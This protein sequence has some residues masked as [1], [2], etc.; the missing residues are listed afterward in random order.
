MIKYLECPDLHYHPG[1]LTDIGARIAEAAR[2]NEVDFIALPGDLYDAPIMATDKGGINELRKIVREWLSVCPVIAIE[3]T[4]SHDGP[5]CYGPLEDMG[6][7]LLKPGTVYGLTEFGIIQLIND[8][9]PRPSAI[10]F[11]IPELNKKQIQAQ[12][13]LPAEQANAEAVNLFTRYVAEFIAPMR[14]KYA[15]LPAIALLHGV[16]SDARKENTTDV[17]IKASDIVIHTEDLRPANI[18]R[19]SLGHIHK[20][21][22]SSEIC[23]GY[24]GSWGKDW[25]EL[26]FKPGMNMVMIDGAVTLSRIHYGTPE[27]RKIIHPLSQY[28]PEIAYLFETDDPDAAAPTGHP[29]SELRY[30]PKPKETRR[31]TKEQADLAKTLQELFKLFDPAAPETAIKKLDEIIEKVKQRSVN[32]ID[33]QLQY[34]K[35]DGCIF[36]KGKSVEFDL[37]TIDGVTELHGEGNGV[38]K[39]GLLAFCS[40][41]PVVIGKDTDSGRASAIKD[42]FEAPDSMVIKKL[43]VNGVQH[44][45]IITIKGAH[46]QTPKVECCLTIDGR[47]QLDKGT[48][49]EMMET[50]EKLY[51][52]YLDY[53]LTTFYVQPLQGT[54]GSSLMSA[55]LIDIRNLVQSIAGIDRE[56]EKEYALLKVKTLTKESDDLTNWLKGAEEFKADISALA[57][58]LTEHEIRRSELSTKLT[59]KKAEGIATKT[60]LT[61][62]T[63]IKQKSD[64]E[65]SRKDADRKRMEQIRVDI[66][67]VEAAIN[68]LKDSAAS[69]DANKKILLNDDEIRKENIRIEKLH[70]DYDA[71]RIRLETAIETERNKIFNAENSLTTDIKIINNNIMA[72]QAQIERIKKP[73]PQCGYIDSNVLTEIKKLERDI[74][75][76]QKEATDKYQALSIIDKETIKK[77]EVDLKALIIPA[78]RIKPTMTDDA[79]KRVEKEIRTGMEADALIKSHTERIVQLSADYDALKKA[80]Y[81]IDE[82]INDYVSAL[83]EKI[84]ILREQHTELSKQCATVDADIQSTK[85]LIQRAQENEKKIQEAEEKIKTLSADIE[86]WQYLSKMF[87]PA[88]LPAFELELVIDAIDAEASRIIEPYYSAKYSFSTETQQHGKK[89]TVDKF[90]IQVHDAETGRATSFVK[91]NPGTKA[92]LNDAYVKALIKQR[93]ERFKRNYS[94][95]ILDEADEPIHPGSLEFFY[96]MQ[97]NYFTDSK[98]IVVSH[99]PASHE[100][101]ENTVYMEELKK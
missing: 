34:V 84:E 18:D 6:L 48:F 36:F 101:I 16:V 31:V 54:T 92:F 19:W 52:P 77:H 45:H 35:I 96:N 32:P 22:E 37:T 79:R 95:I 68:D 50:C 12:L 82:K 64:A 69:V 60:K 8:E 7:V 4:P 23:A 40:P 29:L 2:K 41:Y 33:V 15:D 17:I 73:C 13:N 14:M 46:T 11:G 57:A 65:K 72:Y 51:G 9:G 66:I 99:S 44:E 10:L 1:N 39:S 76:A 80:V 27:R 47:P 61:E 91:F 71:A 30:K 25:T 78:E 43:S 63:I 53:L 42:F 88:K 56:S 55:K 3:G 75:T 49:D 59:D 89:S 90:D 86:D 87:Q 100:H 97:R 81:F 38:G 20:P 83:N 70:T 58:K 24:A 94:P 85:D 74:E 26:G 93:N 5:G 28:D 62:A 21:W 98:V 67:Q